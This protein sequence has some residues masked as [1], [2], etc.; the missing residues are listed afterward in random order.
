[1]T[2]TVYGVFFRD[3]DNITKLY[4]SDGEFLACELSQ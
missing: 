1:M 4:S 3:D 2:A